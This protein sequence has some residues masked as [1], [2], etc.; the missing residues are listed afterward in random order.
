[1]KN[2]SKGFTDLLT[3]TFTSIVGIVYWKNKICRKYTN[4]T[5]M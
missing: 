4:L 5:K 3:S 1:M 2:T